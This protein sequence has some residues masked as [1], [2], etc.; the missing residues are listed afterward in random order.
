M[1]EPAIRQRIFIILS[2]VTDIGKV[3]S[4]DRWALDPGVFIQGFKSA[5]GGKHQLRGWDM[6][7][8]RGI[9]SYDDN[10]EETTAHEYLL[11]GYMSADAGSE[12]V[13]NALIEAVRTAFRFDFTLGG[14]CESAGPV[15]AEVIEMRDF[16]AVVCHYCELRLPVTEVISQG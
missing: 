15:S 7:R 3:Y 9:A 12:Q 14:I 6:R 13:F 4:Y 1:S 16:G 11:R 10:A 8:Q 5:S 2:G